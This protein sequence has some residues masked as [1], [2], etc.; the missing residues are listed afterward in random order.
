[1]LL[2]W[3]ALIGT[4]ACTSG[5]LPAGHCRGHAAR[6][7]HWLRH[8][9]HPKQTR[10]NPNQPRMNFIAVFIGGGSKPRSVCPRSGGQQTGVAFPWGTLASNVLATVLL[11]TLM[12]QASAGATG[13]P[14]KSQPIFLLLPSDSAAPFQRSQ[15]L[16]RIPSCTHPTGWHGRWPTSWPTLPFASRQEP[17]CG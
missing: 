6:C 5:A 17:S 14:A 15:P 12:A 7:L 2:G 3:A 4:A 16:Q 1:M 13:W 10:R 9:A 11:L 8:V